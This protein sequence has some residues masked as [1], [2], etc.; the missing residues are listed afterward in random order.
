M[1]KSS[2]PQIFEFLSMHGLKGKPQFS[3]IHS[4]ANNQVLSVDCDNG[5]WLLKRY[6]TAEHERRSRFYQ[7]KT[8]YNYLQEV[9]LRETVPQALA[10]DEAQRMGLFQFI[11][12]SSLTAEQIGEETI[13]EALSFFSAIN[14]E[15]HRP[16]ALA[17]ANA[18]EA[19]FSIHEHLHCTD[20]RLDRVQAIP[21]KSETDRRASAFVK[22]QL[23]PAWQ[24]LRMRINGECNS[25]SIDTRQPIIPENRCLST[26]DFGFHNAIRL[27]DRR[28]AFFDFEYSGW[29]DPAKTICDFF[30]QPQ[31]PVSLTYW[32]KFVGEVADILDRPFLL[33]ERS[34]LL[35][36][37]YKIKWCCIILNEFLIT[38][39]NRRQFARG[40]SEISETK[41]G[42]QLEKAERALESC[43]KLLEDGWI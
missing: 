18:A 42:E 32:S 1:D 38:G 3:L 22:K 28:I 24:S 15:R 34:R 4:G 40:T 6:F 17:L 16:S 10:W 39:Q 36:P 14:R 13:D 33:T 41:K 21:G 37:A 19:C 9:G 23:L 7:E 27:V 31:V 2:H 11:G 5:R 29:D 43:M 20:R 35:L 26:S 25:L 8:F 30:C 12:G